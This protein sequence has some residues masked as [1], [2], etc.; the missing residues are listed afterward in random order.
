[1]D[2]VTC[3]TPDQLTKTGASNDTI[4]DPSGEGRQT[5]WWA[6]RCGGDL[7]ARHCETGIRLTPR[8]GVRGALISFWL[9]VVGCVVFLFL[10]SKLPDPED[11][12]K[13]K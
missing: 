9:L 10:W 11:Q 13:D 8:R 2:V 4:R 3:G 5:V 6:K 12:D 1:L 7:P